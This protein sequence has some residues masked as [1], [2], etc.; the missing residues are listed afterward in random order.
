ML[1]RLLE[2][3][4]SP[5]TAMAVKAATAAVLAWLL[6]QPFGGVADR[7]PYYAPLGAVIAIGTTFVGSARDTLRGLLGILIGAGL[8]LAVM[9]LAL[10][11]VPALA[12]VVGV[13]TLVAGW[14]RVRPQAGWVP[15]TGLFVL[16]IGRSDPLEF[17]VG[18]LGLTSLGALVGLGVNLAFPPLPLSPAR[19]SASRLRDLLAAQ[20]DDLA[21]G[22]F[23]EEVPSCEEWAARKRAIDPMVRHMRATVDEA[24]EARRGNWRVERWRQE[25]DRQ[26]HQARALEQLAL[27]VQEVAELVTDHAYPGEDAPIGPSVRPAA[28]DALRA[29]AGTLR[30]VEGATADPAALVRADAAVH[31]LR[32]QV[33][34]SR[35]DFADD[36]LVAGT[37]VLTLARALHSLAPQDVTL[38]TRVA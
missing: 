27:L 10:P 16:I 8:A 3:R 29:V 6:V 30:S 31:R 5:R 15:L 35:E 14:W 2:L 12:A 9:L 26:Y 34:R 22:L 18:Y 21:D 24:T 17:A 11:V 38:E 36:M 32:E 23:Q 37:V 20:L 7:L 25:A 4:R 33:R 28:A 13:G 19:S 1:A